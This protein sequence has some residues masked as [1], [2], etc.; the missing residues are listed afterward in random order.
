MVHRMHVIPPI[1][2]RDVLMCEETYSKRETTIKSEADQ[3]LEVS[4][5]DNGDIDGYK[6]HVELWGQRV[7]I[8]AWG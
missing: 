4:R 1:L 2:L 8:S 3:L 6:F 7:M 5:L